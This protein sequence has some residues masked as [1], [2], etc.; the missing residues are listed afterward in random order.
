[1]PEQDNPLDHYRARL[2]HLARL[3]E[4][5]AQTAKIA[6][7]AKAEH[8]IYQASLYA[9]MEASGVPSMRT[10][11]GLFSCKSTA[12]AAVQDREAFT[13]WVHEQGLEDEF[14]RTEEVKGRLNEMVRDILDNGGDMPP[15]INWYPREII[16]FTKPPRK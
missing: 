11:E 2:T 7:D 10:T 4:A 3:K 12:F 9:E 5:K 15:G 8:D 14:L 6:D 16:S 1:M 13:A